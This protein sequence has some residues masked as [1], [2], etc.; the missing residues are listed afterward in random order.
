MVKKDTTIKES[1]MHLT[2][3]A[4]TKTEENITLVPILNKLLYLSISSILISIIIPI[5]F[6]NL[7][8]KYKQSN[9]NDNDIWEIVTFVAIGVCFIGGYIFLYYNIIPKTFTVLLIVIFLLF[10]LSQ[11]TMFMVQIHKSIENNDLDK[12]YQ[13]LW[14]VWFINLLL[15]IAYGYYSI[16]Y[17]STINK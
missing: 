2:E 15:Y 11:M 10:L 1:D 8:R 7:K 6:I 17:L 12:S 9:N 3:E 14:I 16:L 4:E 5:I 13:G